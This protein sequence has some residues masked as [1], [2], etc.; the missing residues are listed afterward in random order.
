M[1]IKAAALLPHPPIVIPEVGGHDSEVVLD[2]YQAMDEVAKRFAQ[3]E[4]ETLVLVSPHGNLFRDAMSVMVAPSLEG[5]LSN[6]G[7]DEINISYEVDLELVEALREKTREFPVLY[8][9][10]EATKSLGSL[11]LDH[12]ATVPLYFMDKRW[13]KKPQILHINY[14]LLEGQELKKFGNLLASAIRELDRRVVLVAS[15]DMSHRLKDRGP[16]DYHEDGPYFDKEVKRIL[17]EGS[18]DD[19]FQMDETMVDN[20]GECGLRSLQVMA[21]ALEDQAWASEVLSYEGPWGV[22]YLIGYLQPSQDNIYVSLVKK[23]L[24][25]KIKKG[26][27]YEPE[28]EFSSLMDKKS[29]CFVTLYKD[30][31][32]RGCIGTIEPSFDNLALEV[33]NNAY[34][35]AFNDPRF[36]RLEEE[37]LQD[38]VISV[39]V[40]GPIEATSYEELDPANYGVIVQSASKR[41]LLL[42]MIEGVDTVEKQVEIASSKAGIREDEDVNYYRFKVVRHAN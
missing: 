8:L 15:G 28:E 4:P 40:L 33:V 19:F 5:D 42:P 25:S 18:L 1:S 27:A 24:E 32:L 13:K 17:E 3:L 20:A 36:P 11:E 31:D 12:G 23:A 30:G 39:D 16:Y 6:F 41:G 2:T 22:G 38:L 14:G 10:E 21:G 37:E 7:T 35:A 34:S 26:R 29:A 9:D